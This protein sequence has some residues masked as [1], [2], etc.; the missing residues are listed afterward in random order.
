MFQVFHW[1]SL[2]LLNYEV[3]NGLRPGAPDSIVLNSWDGDLK[4]TIFNLNYWVSNIIKSQKVKV[5]KKKY[6]LNKDE[7]NCTSVIP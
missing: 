4:K 3:W 2:Q 1:L 7:G 6:S 5:V